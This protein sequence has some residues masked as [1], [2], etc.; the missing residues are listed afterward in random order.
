MKFSPNNPLT[1]TSKVPITILDKSNTSLSWGIVS[2]KCTTRLSTGG[3]HRP[4]FPS[5][6]RHLYVRL[7]SDLQRNH[8]I[9]TS[10]PPRSRCVACSFASEFESE[11]DSVELIITG[12]IPRRS[13]RLWPCSCEGNSV[14]F[15]L[16]FERITDKTWSRDPE[17][18]DVDLGSEFTGW[19][20]SACVSPQRGILPISLC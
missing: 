16:Q 13:H 1:N 10:F 7:F 18:D 17:R 11:N 2:A 4:G 20:P 8:V 12:A 15:S 5:S 3:P 19:V 14:E 6:I 9:M